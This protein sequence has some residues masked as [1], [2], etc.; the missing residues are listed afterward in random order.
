MLLLLF[1][2]WF[3]LFFNVLGVCVCVY[4]FDVCIWE[5]NNKT[6]AA[7]TDK[8]FIGGVSGFFLS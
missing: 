8:T 6:W 4:V 1:V 3:E 7:S 2:F 5:I